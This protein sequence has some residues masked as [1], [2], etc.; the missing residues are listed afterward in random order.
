MLLD[1]AYGCSVD[2][3]ALGILLYQMLVAQSPFSGEDEDKTYDGILTSDPLYPIHMARDAVSILQKLLT[4][5]PER[6]LGSGPTDAQ[7][8]MSHAWFEPVDW[9]DIYNLRVTPPFLPTV[10][11]EMDTS[12]FDSEFT[13]QTP[14]LTPVESGR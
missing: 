14:K 10:E 9:E 2:W 8:I 11:S 6:I 12:N 13:R 1:K 5:D 3:W 7:E 4:R